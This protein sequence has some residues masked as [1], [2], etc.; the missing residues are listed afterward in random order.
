M[1]YSWIWKIIMLN[2]IK[3]TGICLLAAVLTA[4]VIGGIV[5]LMIFGTV[6]LGCGPY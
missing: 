2:A 5:A 4:A 6:A 1:L 3:L